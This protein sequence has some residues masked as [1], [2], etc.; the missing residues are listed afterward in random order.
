MDPVGPLYVRY[1]KVKGKCIE[2]ACIYDHP[3]LSELGVVPEKSDDSVSAPEKEAALQSP[4]EAPVG[5]PC[6]LFY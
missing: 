3:P 1:W 4:G 6:I 5:I 2:D